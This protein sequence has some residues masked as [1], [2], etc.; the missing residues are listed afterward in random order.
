MDERQRMLLLLVLPLAVLGFMM[1]SEQF[2]PKQQDSGSASGSAS[3]SDKASDSVSDRASDRASDSDSVRAHRTQPAKTASIRTDGFVATFT[4]YNTGL[5][6]LKVLGDRFY[7]E[8]GDPQ[9]LVT[10]D[11]EAFLPLA[12][13]VAGATIPADA[14]WSTQPAPDNTLAYRWRGDGITIDRKW[15][16][17]SAPYQLWSTVKITNDSEVTRPITLALNSAHYVR[18]EQEEGGMFGRPS[19]AISHAV[20]HVADELSRLDREELVEAGTAG[21]TF[22]P[23]VEFTGLANLY[24]AIIAAPDGQ[25]GQQCW[26]S[27][28]DRGGTADEPDGTLMLSKL[29]YPATELAPGQSQVFRTKVYAGPKDH[30]AL[31]AFGH[32]AS[33]VIDLGWFSIIAK[34]L[35][36]LLR[37]IH[38]HVPNWGFAIILLTFLVKLLLY[39][40]TEKSFSSMAKM[41]IL[42]PEMDRIN[43]LYADDREKKG[44]A[45]MELYRKEKI[46]PLG[47]C[48]PMLLQ[49]PIWFALYQSLSTNIELYHAPFTAWWQ[50]LSAP[51]PYYVLPIA[52]GAL[53]LLQQKIMPTAAGMDPLQQKMM[54]YGMPI[55]ITVLMLFLPLGLC[56]YMVTNSI[57]SLAQQKFLHVRMDRAAATA[58]VTAARTD[59]SPDPPTQ[60][61]GEDKPK[62]NPRPRPKKAKKKKRKRRG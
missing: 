43:E 57:L 26:L 3:A 52:L 13:D 9:E 62:T 37:S 15:E 2:A 40:L 25:A 8:E 46:N 56:L 53:M 44:A 60:V 23:G 41:R 58:E 34:G 35:N 16:P 59:D 11:K 6:S 36:W 54:M 38:D 49:M 45:I 24:F 33:G 30:D 14:T 61:A 42:K 19:P 18:R 31:L 48:L 22:G 29:V 20:C 55:F 1:M 32:G 10:T 39:P 27:G 51:D 12:I 28:S 4:N 7:D 47:G 50:D 5:V 21:H 17:G